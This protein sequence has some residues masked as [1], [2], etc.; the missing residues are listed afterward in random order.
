[1]L[2]QD[3]TPIHQE[4]GSRVNASVLWRGVRVAASP[5]PRVVLAAH[6]VPGANRHRSSR[7]A[8]CCG[9]SGTRRPSRFAKQLDRLQTRVR[10]GPRLTYGARLTALEAKLAQFRGAPAP[11]A[12]PAGANRPWRRRCSGNRCASSRPPTEAAS[13]TAP[14]SRRAPQRR[15]PRGGAAGIPAT[16]R[17]R[18]GLQP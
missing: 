6:A 14:P 12:P 5:P 2:A 10:V 16:R 3:L 13:P 11:P 15:R 4:E 8:R 9:E 17:D 1:M 7:S 18:R